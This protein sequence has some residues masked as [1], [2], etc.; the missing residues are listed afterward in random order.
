MILLEAILK[1][2]NFSRRTIPQEI[3]SLVV[4]KSINFQLQEDYKFYIDN[5]IEHECFIGS[6]YLK[7]WDL[8]D[9]L[10][11]NN[12]HHIIKYLTN[13]LA[14]GTNGGGECIA[15]EYLGEDNYRVVLFPFID[16]NR[17]NYIEIGHSFTD[18][19]NRLDQGKEWFN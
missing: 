4:E 6:E 12:G 7:L 13:T 8:E 9:I 5:F 1:K 14:I 18:L 16:L 15:I 17:E 11:N 19:L 2:Y 10:E 3:T